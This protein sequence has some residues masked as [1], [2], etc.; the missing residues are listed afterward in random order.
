MKK[1]SNTPEFY[2]QPT[3]FSAEHRRINE[4]DKHDDNKG[5]LTNML[6]ISGY[7][8]KQWSTVYI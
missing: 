3:A 8:E 1:W 2:H 7:R 4:A 5:R 6:K